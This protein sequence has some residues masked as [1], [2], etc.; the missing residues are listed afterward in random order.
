MKI[1]DILNLTEGTLTSKPQIQAIESATAFPS[2]IGQGDLLFASSQ[3]DIDTAVA[4]GAYAIVYDDPEILI[5]DSEIAWIKVTSVKES[6][7][8]LLRYVLLSKEADFY[9]LSKHEMSLFKM[10]LTHKGNITFLPDAWNKAF[11]QILNGDGY[12]FVSSDEELMSLI[13]PESSKLTKEAEGY[14]IDD[15]LFKCTFRI[16]K[17]VYQD[18]KLIPFHLEYLLKVVHLCDNYDLPY[19]IDKIQYTKHFMP[20]YIDNNLHTVTQGSSDKVLIFTDDIKN[21]VRA[22]EYV[23]YQSTWVKSIVLTPPKTKVENVERPYW[24]TTVEEAREILTATH[25]NYAFVYSL[26]KEVFKSFEN[27]INDSGLF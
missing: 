14:A 7:F 11:E 26:D 5:S 27:P 22:R 10:I 18:I 16:R 6:A 12:L 13:K 21:I 24:F 8:R 20:L 23:R 25:Y 15:T 4:N 2:K 1:E 17:Y 3:E 9:L 19:S